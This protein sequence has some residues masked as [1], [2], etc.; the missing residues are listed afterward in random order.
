[1]LNI[2][3][4]GFGRVGSHLYYA[5]KKSAK[6]KLRT[7]IKNSQSKIDVKGISSS[8]VIFICTSDK[9]ISAV[10][11]KLLQSGADLKNKIIFH[12]S[13]AKNSDAIKAL[14]KAGAFT[15]SF[16]PVQTF[17]KIAGRYSGSFEDIF[18][19]LEGDARSIKT[20]VDITR[21]I[22]SKPIKL[23]KEQKVLHHICCV[24]SANYLVALMRNTEALFSKI[25][26]GRIPK[27]GFKD[28]NF[29]DIYK[30]LIVQTLRNIAKIGSISA[31][32][33]PIERNET[34]T[35]VLHLE[36]IRKK[37]P[38][39]LPVYIF[40][41]IETVKTALEKKS[42]SKPDALNLIKLLNKY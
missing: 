19:A 41:G 10:A 31:L 4:I 17:V 12:T 1:L 21:L 37:A 32:T 29:F 18:V 24:L 26:G 20:G 8:D 11:S 36:A 5:L 22:S 39:I 23:T 42:L 25:K 6:A 30:P 13:G 16:H 34:E 38:E 14:K 40:M 3:I 28:I 9:K 33:G 7:V 27:N 15:G 2:S 35:L